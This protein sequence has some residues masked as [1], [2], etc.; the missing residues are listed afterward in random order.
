MSEVV[1]GSTKASAAKIQIAGYKFLYVNV[2]DAL[3][4][5]YG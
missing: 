3:E 4:A 1:L 2:K 5:I